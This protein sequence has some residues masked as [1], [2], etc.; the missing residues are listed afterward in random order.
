MAIET[1]S[2][3]LPPGT[4]WSRSQKRRWAVVAGNTNTSSPS[5]SGPGAPGAGTPGGRGSGQA[6]SAGAGGG[7]L[8]VRAEG[9]HD[10]CHHIL[11]KMYLF[12]QRQDHI[13]MQP[14]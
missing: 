6:G 11:A 10:R 7:L 14:C 12:E 2:A 9:W 8:R 5:G 3:G 13:V 1:F 4:I